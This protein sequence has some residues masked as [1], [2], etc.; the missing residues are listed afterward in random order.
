MGGNQLPLLRSRNVPGYWQPKR[1]PSAVDITTSPRLV[2]AAA[3]VSRRGSR[4]AHSRSPPPART[5]PVHD[6]AGRGAPRW[7]LAQAP[8]FAGFQSPALERLPGEL[9]ARR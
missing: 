6:L 9:R 4:L 5:F 7:L 1:V 2:A 3:A 8:R